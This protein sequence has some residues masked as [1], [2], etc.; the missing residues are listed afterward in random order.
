[1]SSSIFT[2]AI[3]PLLIF[4]CAKASETDTETDPLPTPSDDLNDTGEEEDTDS[5]SDTDQPED[6]GTEKDTSVR[7]A[8]NDE[9]SLLYVQVFKDPDTL[10]SAFAHNHVIRATNWNG[11]LVFD[12]ESPK[13]CSLDFSLPVNGLIPDEDSMR[14]LVGY[15][16][17]ISSGDRE[18]IKG[19]MLDT[20]QLDSGRFSKIA[21]E[22]TNCQGS[23]GV[24]NGQLTVD[25]KLTILGVPMNI[26]IPVDFEIKNNK[27]YASGKFDMS[28]WDFGM[29]PYSAFSGGV[30][31]EEGLFYSFDMV[32]IA[33]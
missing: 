12:P 7:Y 8:F 3:T 33:Q 30:R 9:Q 31:N 16:N 27:F 23:K 11:E 15:N 14:D 4:G 5:N 28:M 17:T 6:T 13:N 29:E 10:L 2:I 22:S 19:H 1:M 26:S 32:G 25:G 21:F 18:T 24:K 20:N